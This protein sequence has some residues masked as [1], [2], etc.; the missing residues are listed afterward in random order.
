MKTLLVVSGWASPKDIWTSVCSLLS[1]EFKIMVVTADEILQDKIKFW[2]ELSVRENNVIGVGWSMGGMLLLEAQQEK[3]FSFESLVLVN[4]CLK[5][6]SE[7]GLVERS[8]AKMRKQLVSDPDGV[9]TN[10]WKHVSDSK[11]EFIEFGRQLKS[12]DEGLRFLTESDI[13]AP[14]VLATVIHGTK[15]QIVPFELGI[16]LAA[17]INGSHFVPVEGG[18]HILPLSHPDLIANEILRISNTRAS[19]R[20]SEAAKTYDYFS[21]PQK[22]IGTELVNR[23]QGISF[24]RSNILDVGCGT[25]FLS[26]LLSKKFPHARVTGIDNADGMIEFCRERFEGQ[27]KATFL[28]M[29]IQN[30]IP[31]GPWD[32]IVSSSALQWVKEFDDCCQKFKNALAPNGKVSFATLVKG[33]FKEFEDSYHQVVSGQSTPIKWRA[34][35]EYFSSLEKAGFEITS[36][37]E[38]TFEFFFT[39]ALEALLH[40]KHI[41]AVEKKPPLSVVLVRKLLKNYGEKFTTND[42]SILM[43]YKVLFVTAEVKQ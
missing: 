40:F 22:Q 17:K 38:K 27:S 6:E 43:S 14:K 24:S 36:T 37:E 42:G 5:M 13:P 23:L 12:L 28:N 25:G 16:S 19:L 35:S 15:D 41:G 2:K 4:S 34:S 8:L 39:T 26:A 7:S 9:L 31:D 29:D 11:T 10:F 32:L 30:Q 3:L 33:S 21:L 20:F 18:T 1:D